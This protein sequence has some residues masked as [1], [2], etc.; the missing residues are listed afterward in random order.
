MAE[1][2]FIFG[3]RRWKYRQMDALTQIEVVSRL[4]S[5]GEALKEIVPLAFKF[6][7]K[8]KAAGSPAADKGA[9]TVGKIEAMWDLVGPVAKAIGK[10]PREDKQFVINSCL[11]LVEV[12]ESNGKGWFPIFDAG[13]ERF[14]YQDMRNDGALVLTVTLRVLGGALG[15]FFGSFLRSFTE[16]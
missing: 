10:M 2:E 7:D 6:Q 3:G 11:A 9:E 5:V 1:G 4:F 13:T 16:L 15:N 12:E 8:M 14:M